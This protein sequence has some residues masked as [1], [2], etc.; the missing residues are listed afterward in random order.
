[1]D[2]DNIETIDVHAL[3]GV[4]AITVNDLTATDVNE[5][6]IDLGANGVGDGS[7]DTIIL[8]ATNGNDVI[9]ITN[10]NGVVTVK[11]LG[12]DVTITDFDVDDSIVINGLGGDDVI[13]ATGLTGMQLVANGGEGDDILIGSAGND[14]L[15]GEAGDDVLIGNGGQDVLDGGPGNNVILPGFFAAPQVASAALLGQFMA[16]SFV[17]A[18]DSHGGMQLAEQSPNQQPLLAQPH[19]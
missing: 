4:D 18:G 9:T 11:G 6:K 10:D 3:G 5:V 2:L 7:A 8:D 14:V 16:S 13:N 12:A 19:A 1:M 17:T 15:H